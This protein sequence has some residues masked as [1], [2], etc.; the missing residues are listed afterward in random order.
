M[1]QVKMAYFLSENQDKCL[2]NNGGYCQTLIRNLTQF[3]TLNTNGLTPLVFFFIF[4]R[5]EKIKW[6][7]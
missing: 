5:K 6:I 4:K 7:K 1:E 2:N 3:L